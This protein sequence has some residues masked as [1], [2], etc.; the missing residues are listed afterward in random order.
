MLICFKVMSEY[1]SAGRLAPSGYKFYCMT[2]KKAGLFR[3]SGDLSNLANV[4]LQFLQNNLTILLWYCR[5]CW[6][7]DILHSMVPGAHHECGGAKHMKDFQIMD[8]EIIHGLETGSQHYPWPDVRIAPPYKYCWFQLPLNTRL[9]HHSS[10][11]PCKCCV[12]LV[13]Y[14]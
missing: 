8:Y 7:S 4:W 13:N 12:V 5:V 1:L 3:R 10:F 2:T 14:N 9:F 6:L 11:M